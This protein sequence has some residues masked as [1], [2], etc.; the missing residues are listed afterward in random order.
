M[1]YPL[2]ML[3]GL[4]VCLKA[5]I[6]G[7]AFMLKALTLHSPTTGT[8][9][10]SSPGRSTPEC[11][12]RQLDLVGAVLNANFRTAIAEKPCGSSEGKPSTGPTPVIER[13]TIELHET[14]APLSGLLNRVTAVARS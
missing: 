11:L 8:T 10:L 2:S 13:K 5:K 12:V 9:V 1:I 14:R 4:R 6:I 3:P 7:L